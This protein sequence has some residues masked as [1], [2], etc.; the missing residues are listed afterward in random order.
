MC[1]NLYKTASP[2]P[3]Q[4]QGH[5]YADPFSHSLI[6]VILVSI[7]IAIIRMISF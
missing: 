4:G 7:I 3:R 5:W 1:E 2:W 6:M